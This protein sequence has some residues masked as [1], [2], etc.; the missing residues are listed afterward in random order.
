MAKRRTGSEGVEVPSATEMV[1]QLA[2]PQACVKPGSRAASTSAEEGRA[3]APGARRKRAAPKEVSVVEEAVAREHEG[4]AA[5]PKSKRSSSRRRSA[6]AEPAVEMATAVE[7]ADAATG[8]GSC[9]ADAE[10]QPRA[11]DLSEVQVA[12]AALGDQALS[13]GDP[14]LGRELENAVGGPAR[15]DGEDLLQVELRVDSVHLAGGDERGDGTSALGVLG[16]AVGE[17]VLPA[18]HDAA[19]RSLAGVVV[20]RDLPVSQELLERLPLVSE[21]DEPFT[22]QRI[23]TGQLR[24]LLIDPG[25]EG[26]DQGSRLAQAGLQ[27]S[28]G[29]EER[30]PLLDAEQVLNDFKAKAGSSFSPA[31]NALKNG[32]LAWLQQPPSRAFPGPKRMLLVDDASA[33]TV[34]S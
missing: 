20:D 5:A 33:T 10:G 32:F 3:A 15:S 4:H 16:A 24:P 18:L 34:P 19:Q 21:V 30:E 1:L 17:P 29:R 11:G 31:L 8:L 6:K 25:E 2:A 12:E 28:L 22:C 27:P 9:G 13:G 14:V 23:A 7:P 26:V